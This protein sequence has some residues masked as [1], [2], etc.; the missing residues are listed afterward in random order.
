M[1]VM[2]LT[3]LLGFT[4]MAVDIGMV[5]V[6]RAQV[7]VAVDAAS[8]AAAGRL[9]GTE[10][11]L[12]AA[13][14]TAAEVA[15][16][17]QVLGTPIAIE[18]DGIVLGRY[19]ED[20]GSVVEETEAALV[21][22]VQIRLLPHDITTSFAAVAFDT[23]SVAVAAQVTARRAAGHG[24]AR[25]TTC[26]L[27]IAVPDCNVSGLAE[28]TNPPPLQ[29]H[30][31]ERTPFTADEQRTADLLRASLD[32][33]EAVY[34]AEYVAAMEDILADSLWPG[35][36]PPST[37]GWAR[38][39]QAPDATWLEAQILD[40]CTGGAIVVGE[41]VF[42]SED[43]FADALDDI[44]DVLD[45]RSSVASEP[46]IDGIATPGRDGV[47]GNLLWNSAVDE[48]AWGHTM[49]GAVALVAADDCDE[50]TF[51]GPLEVTGIAWGA[52]YDARTSG[53]ATNL[54]LQVDVVNAYEVWG[55]VD[56]DGLGNVMGKSKARFA[57]AP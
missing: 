27:P 22:A 12:V 7:Q 21:D 25:S 44:V 55:D 40:R 32:A 14:R 15:A 42:V 41:T 45:E 17:H 38:P 56:E 47:T 20:G 29:I 26:F 23:R 39:E 5:G 19:D 10:S 50:P 13:A 30:M 34:G 31:G 8:L 52:L 24:P 57:G 18:P 11:G 48:R 49:Q 16:A 2:M 1:V 36:V 28:G 51:D 35:G 9:D 33:F 6:G 3:T 37:V 46:W 54:W 43:T 53:S 4:A